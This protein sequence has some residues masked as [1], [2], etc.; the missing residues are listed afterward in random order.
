MTLNL[1]DS[2]VRHHSSNIRDKLTMKKGCDIRKFIDRDLKSDD[3]KK[4]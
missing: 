4:P 2:T 1:E 3:G